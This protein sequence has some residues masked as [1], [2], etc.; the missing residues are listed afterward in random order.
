[1]DTSPIL[2]LQK[3]SS[4]SPLDRI[5]AWKLFYLCLIL[6]G[7]WVLHHY[8]APNYD[9]PVF[10]VN[11]DEYNDHYKDKDI[12]TELESILVEFS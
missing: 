1:M 3:I 7:V 9:H 2:P 8:I 12:Y 10:S 4:T 5:K 11:I 6:T